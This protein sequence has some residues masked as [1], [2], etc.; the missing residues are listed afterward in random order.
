MTTAN[1][2]HIGFRDGKFSTKGLIT[3]KVI[4][5]GLC[6][7]VRNCAELCERRPR[8]KLAWTNSEC[9]HVKQA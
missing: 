2:I 5:A 4:Y 9:A 8:E 7:F 6:G 3:K 1:V